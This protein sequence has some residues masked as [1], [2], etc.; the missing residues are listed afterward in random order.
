MPDI[1]FSND[2]ILALARHIELTTTHTDTLALAVGAFQRIQA[3][4]EGV[5]NDD[6]ASRRIPHRPAGPAVSSLGGTTQ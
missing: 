6:R 3:A 2:E 5:L 4:A 1:P